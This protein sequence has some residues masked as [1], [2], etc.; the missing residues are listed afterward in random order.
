MQ[1]IIT[2]W[3]RMSAP[4]LAATPSTLQRAQLMMQLQRRLIMQQQLL[5]QAWGTAPPLALREAL[6]ALSAQHH[7]QQQGHHSTSTPGVPPHSIQH[8]KQQQTTLKG[9]DVPSAAATA[10][11]VPDNQPANETMVNNTRKRG[12]EQSQDDADDKDAQ[13]TGQLEQQSQRPSAGKNKIK[14]APP[15]AAA[16]AD[17][18]G[19]TAV[20]P[21]AVVG[22][23]R[24]RQEAAVAAG[25]SPAA[26]ETGSGSG[27]AFLNDAA[28]AERSRGKYNHLH[29]GY[30]GQSGDHVQQATAHTGRG[31]FMS[32]PSGAVLQRVAAGMLSLDPSPDHADCDGIM[33]GFELYL[34]SVDD[35]LMSSPAEACQA[36]P[37]RP[38]G[39][40]RPVGTRR[41]GISSRICNGSGTGADVA[42]ICSRPVVEELP[43][44]MQAVLR[45]A[46]AAGISSA[47]LRRTAAR[48]RQLYCRSW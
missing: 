25:S 44:G 26:H 6:S 45:Q 43:A 41:Q 20:R 32:T 31:G 12:R 8:A 33:A 30:D 15:A 36:F 22:R 16:A 48:V 3:L 5:P 4:H 24:R 46:A 34:A 10:K 21:T 39:A 1:L 17:A 28:S 13:H 35:L 14:A 19:R 38:G 29:A 40:W 23:K 9:R 47:V 42:G 2:T 27:T 37:V 7:L 11:L 18:D